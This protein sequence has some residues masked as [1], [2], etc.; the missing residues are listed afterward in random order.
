[1]KLTGRPD[2]PDERR[3]RTLPPC[4][5]GAQPQAPHGPLQR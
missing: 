5:R 3:G 2:A 4:A 1:V